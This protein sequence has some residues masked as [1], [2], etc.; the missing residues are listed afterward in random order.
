M[1][2]RA[3]FAFLAWTATAALAVAA[4]L[5]A[6]AEVGAG[7]TD[8]NVKPMTADQVRA[9]LAEPAPPTPAPATTTPVPTRTMRR[10]APTVTVTARVTPAGLASKGG[11][12]LAV[13]NGSAPYLESWTPLQGYSVTAVQRAAPGPVYVQFESATTQITMTVACRGGR[14]QATVAIAFHFPRHHDYGYGYGGH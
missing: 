8:R 1:T 12:V 3:V 11:Y 9:A 2:N 13:C 7:I 14:P 5:T 6:I 10:P 4:G